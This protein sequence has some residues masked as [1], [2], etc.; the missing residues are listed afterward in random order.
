MNK[1]E[2][3]G[4]KVQIIDE[5]VNPNSYRASRNIPGVQ[6]SRARLTGAYDILNADY[7]VITVSGLKELGEVF[8]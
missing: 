4:K 3:S 6:V 2:L 5:G 1:L 8:G 7:L